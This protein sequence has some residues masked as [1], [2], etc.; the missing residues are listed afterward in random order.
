MIATAEPAVVRLA[1][2]YSDVVESFA[3]AAFPDSTADSGRCSTGA[4]DADA[5]PVD[6]V[7]VTDDCAGFAGCSRPIAGV[8]PAGQVV[9]R[10]IAAVVVVFSD[11]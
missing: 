2:R 8:A 1:E 5:A 10:R 4:P 9:V 11:D 6:P 3:A 7:V